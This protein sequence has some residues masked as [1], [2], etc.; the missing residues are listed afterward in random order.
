MSRLAVVP[1]T[2]DPITNGHMDIVERSLRIFDKVVLAVATNPKKQPLFDLE[3]RMRLARETLEAGIEAVG[4]ESQQFLVSLS[5]IDELRKGSS[6]L[7]G[8]N[9]GN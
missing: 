2:F 7:E 6:D 8:I 9:L 1:G 3:E 4:D 5:R